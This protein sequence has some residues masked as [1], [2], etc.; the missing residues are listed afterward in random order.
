LFR[1][2]VRI[3]YTDRFGDSQTIEIQS[4]AAPHPQGRLHQK[5]SEHVQGIG[6]EVD[7][8]LL[9]GENAIE[10]ED[11]RELEPANTEP[12]QSTARHTARRLSLVWPRL[13]GTL[14]VLCS[15]ACLSILGFDPCCLELAQA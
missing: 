6:G 12:V 8:I 4:T 3:H 13:N 15:A 2:K 14:A 1:T 7:A 10:L 11:T 9:V 5:L